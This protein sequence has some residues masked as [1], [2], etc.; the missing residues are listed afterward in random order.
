MLGVGQEH[1]NLHHTVQMSQIS[2]LPGS[3]AG[4]ERVPSLPVWVQE[5]PAG[6]EARA[7]FL[8]DNVLIFRHLA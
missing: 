1:V 5:S 8:G 4:R 6:W 2:Y 3:P 7:A